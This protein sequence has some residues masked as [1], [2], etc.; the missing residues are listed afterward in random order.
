MAMRDAPSTSSVR[1]RVLTRLAFALGLAVI[2]LGFALDLLPGATPGINLP[3]LI[4]IGL[5]VLL[6]A[7]TALMWSGWRARRRQ[8][9]IGLAISIL[10]LFALEFALAA[11]NVTTYLPDEIETHDYSI[12]PWW[13][14]DAAGC[15]Y[16]FD[17]ATRACDDE[18]LTGRLCIFNRQGF[19]DSQD[20]ILAEP[21]PERRVM[22]LGDSFGQGFTAD[23][24]QSYVET[25]ETRLPDAL[26]WN[27]SVM[28]SGTNQAVASLRAYGPLLQ[29]QLVLLGLYVRDFEDNM[30]PIDSW[31]ALQ[32]G[33]GVAVPMLRKYK[34]DPWGNL[35]A[36]DLDTILYY[37]DRGVFP[38]ANAIESAAARTRIG[39][40]ILRLVDALGYQ[41]AERQYER[42]QAATRHYLRQLR[43]EAANLGSQLLVL[44]IPDRNDIDTPREHYQMALRLF[45]DLRLPYLDV[46]GSLALAD[47]YFSFD[48]WDI[49]WTTAG[50]QKIG[51][52]LADCIEAFYAVGDLREC[53][54]AAI[55]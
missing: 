54:A 7:A 51:A 25:V 26:V 24:G 10:T 37:R 13:A 2:V 6:C 40:L 21:L 19:F 33:D 31:F 15:R 34:I 43:D 9:A 48:V 12:A 23:I 55:P 53:E 45:H 47:D 20:F 8:W 44:L 39:S 30:L 18:V 14:C 49:H 11:M 41:F 29:P 32:D 42:R 36:L 1:Q 22:M 16:D 17:A 50:H 27:L 28:G 52:L 46:R 3:Q 38:P 35:V 4:V 5:G